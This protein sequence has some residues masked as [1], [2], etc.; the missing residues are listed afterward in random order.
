MCRSCSPPQSLSRHFILL[1][2][3]RTLDSE[4]ALLCIQIATWTQLPSQLFGIITNCMRL[5]VY[6]LYA[7]LCKATQKVNGLRHRHAPVK[8]P[9]TSCPKKVCERA[10]EYTHQSCDLSLH[11][12]SCHLLLPGAA[13]SRIEKAGI[14]ALILSLSALSPP[15]PFPSLFLSPSSP[16]F[17]YPPPS[18]PC[19]STL[20]SPSSPCF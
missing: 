5:K 20:F 19:L 1:D 11:S 17:S 6:V 10:L 2:R 9:L 14:K 18:S 15:P 16:C 13:G 4:T 8:S 7:L 12:E 3:I